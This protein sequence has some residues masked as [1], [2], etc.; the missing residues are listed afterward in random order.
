MT[1]I[2]Q[3]PQG[4]FLVAALALEQLRLS[5][6]AVGVAVLLGVPLGGLISRSRR[7]KGPALAAVTLVQ[8]L[9]SLALWG[10]LVPLLGLGTAPA[11]VMVMVL[12]LLPVARH[13][14]AGLD[15]IGGEI[16]EAARG[17]GMTPMQTLVQVQLPLALPVIVRGVRLSAVTAVGLTTLASYIATD[18]L[19]TLLRAGV[20][21]GD[22]SLILA[23]SVP[24]CLLALLVHFLLGRVEKAVVPVSLRPE[25]ALP[26]SREEMLRGKR[27]HKGVLIAIAAVA[28]VLA[29]F[30]AG[31][32]LA[33]SRQ[34]VLE[35]LAHLPR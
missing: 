11:V 32:H 30:L 10:L 15:G 22:P 24:A 21:A 5:A 1:G 12:A 9:P 2:F 4:P 7:L 18:G 27:R 31:V 19:G 35:L 3:S 25:A 17:M 20:Y 29:L 8:D 6:A 13:T 34:E 26:A 33:V 23:G 14:A 16:L 28:A